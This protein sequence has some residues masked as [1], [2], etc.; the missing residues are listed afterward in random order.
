M[1]TEA[2]KWRHGVYVEAAKRLSI[3]PRLVRYRAMHLHLET[4]KVCRKIENEMLQKEQE[5]KKLLEG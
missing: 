2:K 4:I 3:S 1:E 5:A